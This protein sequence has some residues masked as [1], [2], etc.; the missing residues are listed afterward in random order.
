MQPWI[1]TLTSDIDDGGGEGR[2]WVHAAEAERA[3]AEKPATGVTEDLRRARHAAA[4]C[5]DRPRSPETIPITLAAMAYGR[6][7]ADEGWAARPWAARPRATSQDAT[8]TG[9]FRELAPAWRGR[10]RRIQDVALRLGARRP[11][12]AP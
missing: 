1:R 9:A 11:G 2:P 3:A 12:G 7:A 4:G 5:G 6:H 10:W 8:E